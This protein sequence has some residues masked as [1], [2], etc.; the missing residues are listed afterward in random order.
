MLHRLPAAVSSF[1]HAQQFLV[2]ESWTFQ[3]GLVCNYKILTMFAKKREKKQ[4]FLSKECYK[5]LMISMLHNKRYHMHCT[6][7]RN[8]GFLDLAVS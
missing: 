2:S 8:N 5:E 4:L 3:T 6:I 1:E 7:C